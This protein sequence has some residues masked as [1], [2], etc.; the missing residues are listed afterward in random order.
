MVALVLGYGAGRHPVEM[1]GVNEI[2]EEFTNF[3]KE[4]ILL[5]FRGGVNPR[6]R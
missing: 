6:V 4:Q 2:P 1:F 5:A 3:N